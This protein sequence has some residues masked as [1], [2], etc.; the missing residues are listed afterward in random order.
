M[1]RK[2]GRLLTA[3]WA[4]EDFRLLVRDAQRAYMMLFSQ[5]QI[6]N[7]GVLPYVPKKWARLAFDETEGELHSSI[8]VLVDRHFVVLDEETDELLVRTFI[9]HDGVRNLPQLKDAARREFTEIESVPIRRELV[10]GYHDLFGDIAGNG[11][12]APLP[13]PLFGPIE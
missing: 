8:D 13:D 6:N 9:K 2:Y 12:L 11:L 5:P 10:I 1:A 3:I 7:C 4:D